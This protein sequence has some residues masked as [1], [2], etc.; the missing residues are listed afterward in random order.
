MTHVDIPPNNVI[1]SNIGPLIVHPEGLIRDDYLRE[2]ISSQLKI[3]FQAESQPV[4]FGGVGGTSKPHL[5]TPRTQHHGSYPC[6][7]SY[8]CDRSVQLAEQFPPKHIYTP[9]ALH[10]VEGQLTHL[11]PGNCVDPL[12]VERY[13]TE[14]MSRPNYFP[15]SE[16]HPIPLVLFN[17]NLYLLSLGRFLRA[18]PLLGSL[19]GQLL[20]LSFRI[21]TG[22]ILIT[23]SFKCVPEELAFRL[24]KFLA[25]FV[26]FVEE[27]WQLP[28][29]TVNPNFFDASWYEAIEVQ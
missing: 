10:Y 5:H 20:S 1:R 15:E 25:Y 22:L 26:P 11:A 9:L 14:S 24:L 16:R 18:L 13:A 7:N 3:L 12:P 28:C 19:R 8:D 17:V 27:G 29:L 2:N 23:F 4:M 6:S 21:S